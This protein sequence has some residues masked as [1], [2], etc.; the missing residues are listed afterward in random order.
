MGNEHHVSPR[1]GLH[2][3]P[4]FMPSTLDSERIHHARSHRR[5]TPSSAR[6]RARPGRPRTAAAGRA[7]RGSSDSLDPSGRVRSWSS[8]VFRSKG[9]PLGQEGWRK[10]E[11]GLRNSYITQTRPWTRI[12]WRGLGSNQSLYVLRDQSSCE[13]S[14]W[15][16]LII[17][18][19]KLTIA[20]TAMNWAMYYVHIKDQKKKYSTEDSIPS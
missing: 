19:P 11:D 17:W 8:V 5:T 7:V 12:L 15:V 1:W 4:L 20:G 6:R 9:G 13:R 18:R 2:A 14:V 16:D 3:H 10:W